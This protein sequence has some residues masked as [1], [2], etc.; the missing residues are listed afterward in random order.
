ML[1]FKDLKSNFVNNLLQS[2][3]LPSWADE[4][5]PSPLASAE[6]NNSNSGDYIN[7]TYDVIGDSSARPDDYTFKLKRVIDGLVN[8]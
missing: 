1:G 3:T 2:T 4:E 7:G 6:S 5:N 8:F